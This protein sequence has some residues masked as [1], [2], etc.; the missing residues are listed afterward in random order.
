MDDRYQYLLLM[1][2]CVAI[3]L[4]LEFVL[5]A[6]VYRRPARLLAALLPV[7]ALFVAWDVLGIVREHWTYSERYTTGILL[8]LDVPLEELVFFVVIPICGLLTF[9]AVGTVLG[10]VRRW[11]GQDA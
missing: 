4:P 2:G 11:R 8:P 10:W 7:V 1:A 3:T 5:R 9:E 6:R